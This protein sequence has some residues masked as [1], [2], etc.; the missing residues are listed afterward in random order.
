MLDELMDLKERHGCENDIELFNMYM[1]Q[2][3]QKKLML[4][5]LSKLIDK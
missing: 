1:N 5:K 4:K 3:R 2:Q